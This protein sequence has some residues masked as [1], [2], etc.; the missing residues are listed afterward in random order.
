MLSMK[1]KHDA[2]VKRYQLSQ[3]SFHRLKMAE[4]LNRKSVQTDQKFIDS[5]KGQV[6]QAKDLEQILMLK[7]NDLEEEKKSL[8]EQIDEKNDKEA[9]GMVTFLKA[10]LEIKE[11]EVEKVGSELKVQRMAHTMEN[12]KVIDAQR[13]IY[14]IEK[15]LEREKQKNGQLILRLD[16]LQMQYEPEKMVTKGP[17]I[18]KVIE[19]IESSNVTKENTSDDMKSEATTS[20]SKDSSNLVLPNALGLLD[21]FSFQGCIPTSVPELERKAVLCSEDDDV[22]SIPVSEHQDSDDV[23]NPPKK[24]AKGC[25]YSNVSKAEP[26]FTE[27]QCTTQ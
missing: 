16:E 5:L 15:A 21:I 9:D 1:A 4:A 23:E 3:Q 12:T 27:E 24:K 13:H 22:T 20:S 25:K 26:M 11:R 19:V 14:A 2:L 6:N 17:K 18:T 7:I 8:W 10:Q